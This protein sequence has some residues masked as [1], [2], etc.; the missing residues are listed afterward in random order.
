MTQTV[1]F[2]FSI[3][4]QIF[5]IRYLKYYEHIYKTSIFFLQTFH[6]DLNF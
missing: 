4:H 3:C 6:K 2:L 5:I 1:M